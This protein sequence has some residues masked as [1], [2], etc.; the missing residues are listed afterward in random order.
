MNILIIIGVALGLYL[1][2]RVINLAV[3]RVLGGRSPGG[4]YLVFRVIAE[5]VVWVYFY[6]WAMDRLLSG[7][8]YY[9]TLLVVSVLIILLFFA[10]YVFRDVLVGVLFKVQY[11]PVAGQHFHFG[12]VSGILKRIG[13]TSLTLATAE[14]DELNIPYSKVINTVTG[15]TQ[16]K[17]LDDASIKLLMAKKL[18]K[19][20]S[21]NKIRESLLNSPWNPVKK[22]PV[23]KVLSESDTHYEFEITLGTT[24][25]SHLARIEERLKK[26][27]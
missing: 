16:K 11:R 2:F 15:N 22:P 1:F 7:K 17:V 27:V 10:W 8:S 14:G 21:I 4:N 9:T 6:F 19:E 25:A 3:Q 12:E 18:S 26:E 20:D 24:N 23:I 5:F 13:T